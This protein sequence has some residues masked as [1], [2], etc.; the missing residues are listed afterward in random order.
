MRRSFKVIIIYDQS[1]DLSVFFLLRKFTSLLCWNK[2]KLCA[3]YEHCKNHRDA[4]SNV[5]DGRIIKRH[6]TAKLYHVLGK[7]VIM[8]RPFLRHQRA[9]LPLGCNGMQ[10]PIYTR[11][12][13]H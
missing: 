7:I 3:Q 9:N 13:L 11:L 8:I 1:F 10:C 2:W 5:N 4:T 12:F 6:F